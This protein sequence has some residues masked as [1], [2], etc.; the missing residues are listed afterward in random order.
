MDL[1]TWRV[2]VALGVVKMEANLEWARNMNGKGNFTCI[3]RAFVVFAFKWE[4]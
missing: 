1:A 4:I 3:F 2:L